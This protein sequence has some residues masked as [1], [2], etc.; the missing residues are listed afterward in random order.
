MELNFN[1][2]ELVARM[3]ND[4]KFYLENFCKIKT[5]DRGLQKWT[6]NEAQ[7]DIANTV[8]Q[9]SRM[10]F[11]KSRQIGGS[12]VVTGLWYHFSIFN[13]GVNACL[14]GYNSELTKEFMEKVKIFY[15][16]TPDKL[17]PT[18]EYNTKSEITFGQSK[19]KLFLLSASENVGKGWTL[20]RALCVSGNTVVYKFNKLDSI[21]AFPNLFTTKALEKDNPPDTL[22]PD[23]CSKQY[24]EDSFTPVFVKDIVPG[25]IIM[26]G[27]GFLSTVKKVV[28]RRNKKELLTIKTFNGLPVTVTSDHRILALGPDSEDRKSWHP[29]KDLTLQDYIGYPLLSPGFV[30]NISDYLVTPGMYWDRVESISNAD[31]EYFVYDIVLDSEPHSFLTQGGVVH[32]CSELPYWDKAEEK[33]QS[34]E[35]SVPIQGKLVIESTPGTLTD[36]FYR[37]FI[38]EDNGYAKREYGWWWVYSPEEANLIKKRMNDPLKFA[39]EYELAFASTGRNVFDMDLVGRH[40]KN[41]LKVGDEVIL[42]EFGTRHLVYERPDRLRIFRPPEKNQ[43]YVL[44]ADVAEGLYGGDYS[45]ATIFNRKTGEEVAFFR[46]HI[47]PDQ[48]ATLL[49]EWGRIYNEALVVPEVNGSGIAVVSALKLLYYPNLYYRPSKFESM[50]M[51]YSD[52]FGWRTTQLTRPLMLDDFR[53]A[54]REGSI[55]VHSKETIDELLTFIFDSNG[56]MRCEKGTHDDCIFS[57]AIALQGFKCLWVNNLDQINTE[58]ILPEHF[59]Y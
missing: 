34:L 31:F 27:E 14:I 26:N 50:Q 8:A 6:W 11:G 18:L 2:E 36:L 52:K 9:N 47:P 57:V 51:S 23:G 35:S 25:D 56:D 33:M 30:P 13:Y 10:I 53:K 21:G 3:R 22:F 28:R 39:Q 48:F 59:V 29:A 16:T 40:R 7:K 1:N 32:N 46:A 43:T 38:A 45:V 20:H 5:K 54:M 15:S 17:K 42:D 24:T 4:P 44:S 12:T 49:N 19:S 58:N 55:V 37:M 41:Q